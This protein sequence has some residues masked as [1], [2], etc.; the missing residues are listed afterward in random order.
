MAPNPVY[1]TTTYLKA[2][3]P[4]PLPMCVDVVRGDIGMHSSKISNT[5]SRTLVSRMTGGDTSH[6]TMSDSQQAN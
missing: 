3:Q 5:G 1:V 4:S 6:Y 2:T